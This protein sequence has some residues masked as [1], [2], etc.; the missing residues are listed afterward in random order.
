MLEKVAIICNLRAKRWKQW[1]LKDQAEGHQSYIELWSFH[2]ISMMRDS[3]FWNC[4]WD[5]VLV[6]NTSWPVASVLK[7]GGVDHITC[8]FG[9]RSKRRTRR[10]QQQWRS[11]RILWRPC[12]SSMR[13]MRFGEIL[14]A[15]CDL[16][17]QTRRRNWTAQ[18]KARS[19]IPMSS[20]RS[21]KGQWLLFSSLV[22]K[23]PKQ[24]FADPSERK[25]WPRHVHSASFINE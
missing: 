12:R 8:F 11:M 13:S 6:D 17:T 5:R 23:K 14:Q 20:A 18:G 3:S 21:S 22:Q 25:K 7:H 1:V 4:L 16:C 10:L 19:G 15:D 2:K 24:V 9:R